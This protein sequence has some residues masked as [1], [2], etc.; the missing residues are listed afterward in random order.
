MLIGIDASRANKPIKTGTEWYSYHLIQWFKK[1]DKDNHYFLYTN[2]PL[3]RGLGKCP[4]NFEEK[5][6]NWPPG[7]LW[8]QFRLSWEMIK[9]RKK[10]D[11]LFVSAHVIP[12]IH[13]KNTTVTIHDIGFERFP[14]IYPWYDIV[15]HKWAVRFAKYR[16]KKII[17]IS[18]FSKKELINVFKIKPEKIH[19]IYNGYDKKM[20]RPYDRKEIKSIEQKYHLNFSYFIFIGRLEEKKNT[21]FLIECFAKFKQKNPD[22][23]HKLV[24]IGRKGHG[25]EKIEENIKKYGLENEIIFPGWIQ[26]EDLAKILAGAEAMIFP[27]LY[28]GFGIPVIEAMACAVPVVCSNTASLPE[29]ADDAAILID[30]KNKEQIVSG[31]EKVIFNENLRNDLIEKGLGNVKRF[32]WGNCARETLKVILG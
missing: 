12:M 9:R 21:P 16:A 27:S 23:K 24:L 29:V 17:T 14:E 25:F 18:K 13:P 7:R 20:Y 19:V 4:K 15:Y 11:A 28:E 5:V 3:K 8:T 22:S 26:T 6:L 1:L 2:V 31:M 30:P 10:I 32:S